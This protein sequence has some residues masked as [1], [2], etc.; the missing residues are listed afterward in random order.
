MSS[1]SQPSFPKPER[2]GWKIGETGF[3]IDW[4]GGD[5]VVKELQDIMSDDY[6]ND[7]H[8]SDDSSDD[9]EDIESD[10]SDDNN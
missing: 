7:D 10:N 8:F 2:N 4:Y 6:E 9:E 3:E 5:F 1:V